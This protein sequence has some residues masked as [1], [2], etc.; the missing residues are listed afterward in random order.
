MTTALIS[1]QSHLV[2]VAYLEHQDITYLDADQLSRQGLTDDIY[3]GRVL[4]KQHAYYWIDVGLSRPGLLGHEKDFQSLNEGD[5]VIVQIT[6]EAFLDA[7]EITNS[8]QKG[9]RLTRNLCYIS[10]G[11]VYSPYRLQP[12]SQRH[13]S[14]LAKEA[15]PEQLTA[16]HRE[17]L[18]TLK[19]NKVQ[20]AHP[21]PNVV[22]RFLRDIPAATTILVNDYVLLAACQDFCRQWRPDLMEN[23][24]YQSGN[25]FEEYGVADAWES[26]IIPAICH[27]DIQIVIE[28][29]SCLTAIDVNGDFSQSGQINSKAVKIIAEQ[30]QWRRI[31]GNVMIDFISPHPAERRQLLEKMQSALALYKPKWQVVGWSRLGFCELQRARHRLSLRQVI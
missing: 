20:L 27:E 13:N 31:S 12:I 1:L 3:V 2:K 17:V 7:A 4:R 6:R 8:G 10:P 21:G 22:Q 29:T 30:L 5:Y 28:E 23:L 18:A 14:Q 15:L 19:L 9:V 24:R 25:L 16:L 26:C 11:I